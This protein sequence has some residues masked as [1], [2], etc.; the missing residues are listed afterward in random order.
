MTPAAEEEVI[1]ASSE[2][3]SLAEHEVISRNAATIYH[4]L[5]FASSYLSVMAN[6]SVTYPS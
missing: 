6:I 2:S 3:V 5:F 4:P 1:C